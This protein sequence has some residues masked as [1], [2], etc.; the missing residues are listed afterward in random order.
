MSEERHPALDHDP[1]Q[2]STAFINYNET[3]VDFLGATA[4]TCQATVTVYSGNISPVEAWS[5][6]EAARIASHVGMIKA[7]E[8]LIRKLRGGL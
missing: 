8:E 1:R 5:T 2:I 7:M 6:P 3:T 4:Y